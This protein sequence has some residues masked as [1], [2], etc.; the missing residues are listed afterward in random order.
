MSR[1]DKALITY[2]VIILLVCYL[3]PSFI[4]WD[5]NPGNWEQGDRMYIGLIWMALQLLNPII[6]SEFKK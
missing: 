3:V 6:Y 5:S 1:L 4:F 2:Q